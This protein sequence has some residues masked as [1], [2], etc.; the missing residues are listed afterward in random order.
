VKKVYTNLFIGSD[1]DCNTCIINPEFYI[2]HACK[3][4]HQRAVGYKGS[5]PST[6][7]NYLI[8]ENGAHLFLNMV[9]MP[10]EL[11]PKF[12]NPIFNCSMNF[13]NRE[14]QNKKILIHCNMGQSRSPSIGLAYLAITGVISNNSYE[15]AIKEFKVF[16]PEYLPGAGIMLY[17]RHNWD[18]LMNIS[19]CMRILN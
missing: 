14:I 9:D 16:Y 6:H 18:F 11:L 10:N 3:T 4:C 8:Y 12:T 17:M 1:D 5:L 19:C 2:I 7:P 15:T 13:I